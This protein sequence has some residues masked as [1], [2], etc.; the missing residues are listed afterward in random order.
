MHSRK[1]CNFISK[2]S[3]KSFFSA[4]FFMLLV[5][6]EKAAYSAVSQML[7]DNFY[8]NPAGLSLVN[9]IQAIAGNIF[10]T[11]SF[12]FN[13]IS[14]GKNGTAVSK[15]SDSLPYI[16][17]AYRLTEKI[18]FGINVTPSG[19]G[20]L[21]WPLDSIVAANST[22]TNLLYYRAGFQSNYQF[23][24]KL[25]LGAGF[26]LENNKRLALNFLVPNICNEVNQVRGLNYSADLG[27]LYKIT[28]KHLINAVI[29]SPV[30][31]IGNGT[32]SLGAIK[33]NDFSLN[34]SE[35]AVLSVGLQH[36]FN[37]RWSLEE[38]IYWSGWS[39]QKNIVYTNSA[40]GTY[41]VPTNW[42]D[43]FS[44]QILTRVATTEKIALLGSIIYET[45]PAP[46]STNAIGYPLS[47]LA[48]ISAGFDA[49]LL[50][51]FSAQILYGYGA[52]IPEAKIDSSGNNGSITLATQAVVLQ[53]TYKG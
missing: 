8:Q 5:L 25:T 4:S 20:H 34:I 51:K 1:T 22:E 13:G 2:L 29:Y 11:P 3:L 12:K 7:N 41:T 47:S 32:S 21:K 6:F 16:L 50:Q 36:S 14:L 31:A 38:K 10:I 23:T 46:V 53:F 40:T 49:V 15:V 26:N 30:N 52:F 45:N 42:K 33:K 39:M 43:V 9:N 48:F 17:T 18:V 27:V 28:S 35:A 44:Y 24:D 37:D 19:Y